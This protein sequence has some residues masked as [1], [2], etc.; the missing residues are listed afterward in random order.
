MKRRKRIRRKRAE[1]EA[2]KHVPNVGLDQLWE[3]V[4]RGNLITSLLNP[5]VLGHFQ[6]S[7]HGVRFT[8]VLL[9]Q[10]FDLLNRF[11]RVVFKIDADIDAVSDLKE[12][13]QKAEAALFAI[14]EPVFPKVDLIVNHSGILRKVGKVVI[15]DEFALIL[16]PADSLKFIV[17][18]DN[19]L[20]VLGKLDI[21]L[22]EVK[23]KLKR[24]LE[25]FKGV[26]R[27][28]CRPSPMRTE[29]FPTSE[30]LL[31]LP[32]GELFILLKLELCSLLHADTEPH[33]D[34]V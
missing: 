1:K 17:M 31:S 21:T 27:R 16:R 20:T 14:L 6:A 2:A 18:R 28:L 32:Q 3:S 34:T 22:H 5:S 4:E 13:S 11:R 25:G 8:L 10:C 29:E 19:H 33:E 23:A 12:V 9:N 24:L 7:P 26:F 30:I 15:T